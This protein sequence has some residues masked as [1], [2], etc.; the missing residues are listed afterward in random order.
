MRRYVMLRNAMLLS[1]DEAVAKDGIT[2]IWAK[3]VFNADKDDNC[4]YLVEGK[5]WG[6]FFLSVPC[7]KVHMLEGEVPAGYEIIY[8]NNQWL[9]L[10]PDYKLEHRHG[11]PLNKNQF[12]QGLEKY[13]EC[14]GVNR[15][16]C[17]GGKFTGLLGKGTVLYIDTYSE[18][19]CKD[20]SD[21]LNSNSNTPNGS[22][23]CR[24]T[25]Y[26]EMPLDVVYEYGT[27]YSKE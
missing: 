6:E 5:N 2:R 9:S 19:D 25:R 4:D 26:K 20:I 24:P 12:L 16:Y 27:F 17:K 22:A 23:V 7:G 18:A 1:Y 3:G 14:F 10:L 13:L 15:V 8:E 11:K 21:Y